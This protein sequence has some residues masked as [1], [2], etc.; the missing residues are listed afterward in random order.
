[1]IKHS[2]RFGDE[3]W[4]AGI[5]KHA[6][7]SATGDVALVP[8]RFHTASMSGQALKGLIEKKCAGFE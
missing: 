2:L 6:S 3:F 4:Q 1:L 5:S 8:V 7:H